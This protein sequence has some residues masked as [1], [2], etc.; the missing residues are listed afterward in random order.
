MWRQLGGVYRPDPANP[1]TPRRH[2]EPA[3]QPKLYGRYG[4]ASGV[5]PACLW[6]APRQ[7]AQIQAEERELFPSLRQMEA[8]LDAQEREEAERRRK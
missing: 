2:L 1:K 7:L 4:A 8:A 3:Y 5:D 6:P